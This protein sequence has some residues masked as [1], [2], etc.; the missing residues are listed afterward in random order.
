VRILI[1]TARF[2]RAG[3]KG[4]QQRGLQFARLLAPHHHVTVA[5][6]ARA[7]S[8][9]DRAELERVAELHPLAAG[10]ARRLAGALGAVPRGL[11]LQVG[12]MMPG[13]AAREVAAV[14]AGADVVI[15]I[16]VRCLRGQL[17]APTVLDHI[18]ALSL[19][20][21]ERARLGRHKPVRAAALIEAWLLSRHERRAARWVAAQT[22][23][24]PRDAAA[25]PRRPPPVVLPL[26]FEPD[27]RSDTGDRDIDVIMTGDMR[28]PP[29]RDGAEWLAA[30]IVPAL[31][32]RD[33][34]V[35]VVIAGRAAATL[36]KTAGVELLSDVDDVGQLLRRS[37]V[38]VVPLRRGTGTPIKLL[39]AASGGAAPVTTPWVATALGIDVDTASDATAFAATI[40]RLL[41]DEPLR[42]RRVE[43]ARDG[44]ALHA[45]AAVAR[46]LLAL[47]EQVRQS[48]AT[49]CDRGRETL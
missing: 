39:E 3:G 19:N 45:P 28:Y 38:A 4:D 12:W 24:S 9:G 15:A 44:L 37:R 43:A 34:N 27:E 11:P 32:R 17:P 14:A 41:A 22:V 30:E 31:R 5:T 42:L 25:L 13:A 10:H 49:T 21:R 35:R 1:V 47:L 23:V 46:Q 20:M 29:N 6:A 16:T 48:G 26:V 8:P 2:P 7:P 36:P 33:A 18:D 40:E